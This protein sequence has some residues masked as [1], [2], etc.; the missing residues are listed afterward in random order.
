LAAIAPELGYGLNRFIIILLESLS[1]SPR[2]RSMIRTRLFDTLARASGV[3][4][5]M[6]ILGQLFANLHR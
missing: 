2:G 1:N 4:A 6:M 5:A 3:L